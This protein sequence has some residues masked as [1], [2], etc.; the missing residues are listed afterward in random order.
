MSLSLAGEALRAVALRFPPRPAEDDW[1]ATVATQA[2]ILARLQQPPLR[3]ANVKLHRARIRGSRQILQWLGTFPGATWQ[4]RWNASPASTRP[5]NDWA[6]LAPAWIGIAAGPSQRQTLSGGLLSLICADV[7]RPTLPWLLS[8][9]S[10]NMTSLRIGLISTRDPEG[11]AQLEAMIEPDTWSSNVGRHALHSLVKIV[12]A[13]GGTLADITVGDAVEYLAALKTANDRS[14]GYTLFYAWLQKLGTLPAEAPSSLRYLAN[15]SGQVSM[16]QLIDRFGVRCQPVR[17]LLVDYLKERQPGLDYT[18]LNNL[19][20]HLASNF[21]GDLEQ[22]HP[23][24]DSLHLAPEVSAAWKQ[25][26]RTRIERRRQPDGTVREAVTA[27]VNI[28]SIMIS[29]RAFYLDIAQWAID[30]PARWGSWAVPSPIKDADVAVV[31]DN[32]RRKARMDHRTR[33]RLPALPAVAR[34]ASSCLNEAKARLQALTDTAPGD[35]F[36][37]AGDTFTR[38]AKDGTTWA[39]NMATGRRIDLGLAESRAFWAWAMIEFLQHTGV[40]IEE[41]LEASHHS[42]IQYRLPTTDE[43]VP[44]LQIAPSKTDEER[45]ILVSPELADVLSAIIARIRDPRTGAVP[46]VSSYDMAEKTWNPQMPLLFQW[47]RSGESSRLSPKFL[48]QA[49]QEVLASTNLTDSAG[50]PL[51]FS[52]HDFRRIFITDAIRSGL[53]PHIAQVIAGH[54]NINTT[55]G[56]NAIYPSE[57]IEAHRAFIARRRALRP[58]EE[59]RTPTNEEWDA[60]LGHFERRKLSI[61]ICARAFGTP[62]IHEHAC[63][64]CSMLRPD[65]AQRHRLLD[66]RDNLIARITEAEQEGWLGEIEG[67]QVSLASA[68]EKLTQLDAEQV[69]QHQVI[70]LGMPRFSQIATRSSTARG[71]LS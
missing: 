63:I 7:I 42:L 71:P 65:P 19:S 60:F 62:C 32:K 31:K 41:M 14:T 43:I 38:A 35:Q 8:R 6:R 47:R 20:R 13:K 11:F 3:P 51:D 1:A 52:P 12:A 16:E 18:S 39:V 44:L 48:R 59:Y 21:W 23:G 36:A 49:L 34:A 53:P 33:E 58:S 28:A 70:D 29:V 67:L 61:G 22:H 24:I 10:A 69:R 17:D 55:M 37:F 68:E 25:R 50:Q 46:Y 45:V 57:A 5:G 4:Q 64:R 15:T 30:E 2:D 56:Y 40:R 26:C 27:R 9:T 66:I 54:T